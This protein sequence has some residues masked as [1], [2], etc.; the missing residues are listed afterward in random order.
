LAQQGAIFLCTIRGE[1]FSQ[2]IHIRGKQKGTTIRVEKLE[3]K[4]GQ[5]YRLVWDIQ[6]QRK[7]E[8]AP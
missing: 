3:A 5:K 1:H 8:Q 4:E 2:D 7:V 6:E